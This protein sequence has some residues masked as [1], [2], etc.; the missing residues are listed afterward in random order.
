MADEV[1]ARMGDA[2]DVFGIS[3]I[4]ERGLLDSKIDF[5]IQGI[6]AGAH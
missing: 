6:E 5:I 3:S 4:G 2:P 1:L